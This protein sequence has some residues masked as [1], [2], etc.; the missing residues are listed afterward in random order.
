[1]CSTCF[2]RMTVELESAPLVEK[3]FAI[4]LL[5]T[6]R[7]ILRAKTFCPSFG[8][9]AKRDSHTRAKVP[10]QRINLGYRMYM[11]NLPV[12]IVLIN[13]KS[14]TLNCLDGAPISLLRG[15]SA[16]WLGER[17]GPL[18]SKHAMKSFSF[19]FCSSSIGFSLAK[20]L[21]LVRNSLWP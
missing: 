20:L 12:P 2:K 16:I 10:G 17:G 15:F 18:H 9:P 13:S 19:C 6:L 14:P 7:S 8:D 3:S 1:M 21:L 4:H 5:S 11:A